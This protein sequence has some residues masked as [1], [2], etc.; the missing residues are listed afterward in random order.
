[1]PSPSCTGKPLSV[2][3]SAT[4]QAYHR[5]MPNVPIQCDGRHP[6]CARCTSSNRQCEGYARHPVFLNRTLSGIQPRHHLEEAIPASSSAPR[7][8]RGSIATVLPSDS[9]VRMSVGPG[10][11]E[12]PRPDPQLS[13]GPRISGFAVNDAQTFAA[14]LH[15]YLPT[16]SLSSSSSSSLSDA[17]GNPH[18]L[19]LCPGLSDP[20]TAFALAL[21]ALSLNRLGAAA[22]DE[23][24][25]HESRRTYANALREVQRALYDER[26]MC[27]DVTL[28]AVRACM[29]YEV[30]D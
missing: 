5:L 26:Q 9:G 17:S 21:R 22:G 27:K 10:A 30:S 4:P 1:M 20:G 23:R 16:P 18:W 12:L 14:F 13:V 11:L 2:S 15:I 19:S 7:P 28:A 6:T 3:S 8:Y 25:L 24:V 29:I